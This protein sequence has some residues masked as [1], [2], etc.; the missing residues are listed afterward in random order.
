MTNLPPAQESYAEVALAA[1]IRANLRGVKSPLDAAMKSIA[2]SDGR[3]LGAILHAPAELSN[4][5]PT[6]WAAVRYRARATLHPEQTIA[7]SLFAISATQHD[8]KRIISP[9]RP[10]RPV[11]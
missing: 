1:E 5:T 8:G 3:F 6:D 7:P 11:D 10:Y 2:A 4:L 9:F